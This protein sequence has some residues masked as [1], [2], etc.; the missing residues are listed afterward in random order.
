VPYTRAM[1]HDAGWQW[2]IPLQSRVGNGIVYCSRYLDQEAAM[3]R[4]LGNI[5]GE[6]LTKPNVLRFGA[7]MRQKQWHRNCV[8]VG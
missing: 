3:E 1:A 6:V 2:R 5:E 7:G 4:L 8:A